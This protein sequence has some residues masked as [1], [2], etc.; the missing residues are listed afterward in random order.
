MKKIGVITGT[1]AD[2]GILRILIDEICESE[3]LELIIYVTGIHLLRKYG[4]TISLIEED[5]FYNYIKIVPMYREDLSLGS[6]IARGIIN[7]TNE[8]NY[9]KPDMILVLGDRYE[10]LSA[11]ISASTLNIPI[12]HIHGGDSVPLGQIDEQIRHAITKFAHIH[13]PATEK[14]AE[15]IR[16]MG[17]ESWRIHIVGSPAVDMIKLYSNDLWDKKEVYDELD[18]DSS[19]KIVTCIY[20]SFIPEYKKSGE[21]MKHILISLDKFDIQVVVIY[22]NNDKGSEQI[23][24]EIEKFRNNKK[25]KIYKNLE[26]GLYLSLLSISDLMIGNSSSGIID[27]LTFKLPVINIGNRN[28]GRESGINVLNTPIFHKIS[29]DDIITLALSDAFKERCKDTKQI[30]GDGNSS[31]KIVKILEDLKIDKKLLIK[32]MTY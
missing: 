14:S 13:F 21:N 27:T 16:R 24:E 11:V 2:Y 8:F 1:R 9:D 25:F 10:M 30:Y 31:K 26:R 19:K 7:F 28:L 29:F 4:S 18:L 6:A 3:K 5:G 20:H 12:A 32:K 17:E 23:I 22:P 15:R